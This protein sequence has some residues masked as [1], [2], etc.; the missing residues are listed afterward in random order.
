MSVKSTVSYWLLTPL[1]LASLPAHALNNVSGSL[2][3]RPD[4]SGPVISRDVFGQF[5]EHLGEGI[6][7]GVWVGKASKI[8]NVRGIRSDVVTALRALKVPVVRWPGGCFADEYDWRKGIGPAR[9]R[10]ATSTETGAMLLSPTAS[11]RTSSWTSWARSAARPI[12][13][14]MWPLALRGKRPSGWNI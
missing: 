1:A 9:Q 5:A 11:A 4:R 7:G 6:Y 12:S 13:T 3:I 8:P 10:I 2:T 14:S